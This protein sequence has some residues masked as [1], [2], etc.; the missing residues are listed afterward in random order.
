ML[1]YGRKPFLPIAAVVAL[2]I[3]LGCDITSSNRSEDIEANTLKTPVETVTPAET[4]EPTARVDTADQIPDVPAEEDELTRLQ[5]QSAAGDAES[6][7]QLACLYYW[8]GKGICPS[9]AEAFR[10][11]K[12][13]ADEEHFHARIRLP[14][15]FYFGKGT[16]ENKEEAIV[17]LQAIFEE[18]K[19]T[20]ED[21]DAE[22]NFALGQ[23]Y[24][25]GILIP[26]DETKKW[27]H[28]EKAA[29]AGHAPAAASLGSKYDDSRDAADLALA[30]EWGIKAAELGYSFAQ[31]A[32]VYRY[33]DGRGL[34]IDEGEAERWLREAAASGMP[35]A[36]LKLAQLIEEKGYADE[37][38]SVEDL[39]LTARKCL[40]SQA[41]EGDKDA[42]CRLGVSLLA[43]GALPAETERGLKLLEEAAADNS[44]R[45]LVEL[46]NYYAS[47]ESKTTVIEQREQWFSQARD[48]ASQKAA[49]GNVDAQKILAQLYLNGLG[50][51]KDIQ[52][53]LRWYE[54]AA[55]QND[56]NAMLQ[57][58]SFCRWSDPEKA[59]EWMRKA[60][61][62][63]VPEAH[64]QLAEFCM[65]RALMDPTHRSSEN[66]TEGIRNYDRAAQRGHLNA[67]LRLAEYNELPISLSEEMLS[68]RWPGLYS[69][70]Q[71]SYSS[72]AHWYSK[73]AERGERKAHY[74]LGIMHMEGNGVRQHY[75]KAREHLEIA[76]TQGYFW[77]QYV[78]GDLLAEP[79]Y[80]QQD[81]VE[82]YKWYILAT[83]Q[84][85]NMDTSGLRVNI[86]P[87]LAS[88]KDSMAS[89][90]KKMTPKMI[91]DAQNRAANFVPQVQP[92][93]T[94]E[95]PAGISAPVP[96]FQHSG[97][98][99]FVSDTGWM[100]TAAHVVDG[101]DEVVVEQGGV[102][103]PARVVQRDAA[104]DVALLK[105]EGAFKALELGSTQDIHPGDDVFTVGFPNVEIQGKEPKVNKGS[106]AALTG[107]Q[108]DPRL[109]Q[110]SVPIGPG[111]SGAP[112]LNSKGEVVGMLVSKLNEVATFEATGS[113]PQSVNY[114]LK[115]DYLAPMLATVPLEERMEVSERH[116]KLDPVQR[117]LEACALVITPSP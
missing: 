56:V 29:N 100:L 35:E 98:G 50:G 28:Y 51:E 1:I 72:A 49:D 5:R 91:A 112:L 52:E 62:S 74:E 39:I 57:L 80:G 64:F 75:G 27:E 90:R 81:L 47:E 106:I 18:L 9:D 110:V 84:P 86:P 36:Q 83:E 41:S 79:Q 77:A 82:A 60:T 48:L 93:M 21:G 24:G 63:G 31:M 71:P 20:A 116:S 46:G 96:P 42:K 101:A 10:L 55:E 67:M 2:N 117:A 43:A 87:P 103:L 70:I 34:P 105:A 32:L 58:A 30:S 33:R 111:N 14:F 15:L 115:V 104:N 78:L 108:D 8:G 97:T 3:L 53:G 22:A 44:L 11:F 99:F 13:A 85:T 113:L 7:Y 68:E 6:Q 92:T 37:L 94:A 4:Q 25:E 45:A 38:A 59:H 19:S 102:Q 88:V 61:I 66:T 12:A 76:A 65:N 40:E 54:A 89:L 17:L 26:Q 16:E 109:L 107:F 69:V 114:A 23:M 95:A 73:A